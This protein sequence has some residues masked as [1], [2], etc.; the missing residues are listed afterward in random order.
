M[1][2][3]IAA[4]RAEGAAELAL[5]DVADTPAAIAEC[6]AY[7]KRQ[8]EF[9]SLYA[10]PRHSLHGELLAQAATNSTLLELVIEE[11]EDVAVSA[12]LAA[13]ASSAA[14]KL[15]VLRLNTPIL[16]AEEL[17]K[18]LERL[19]TLRELYLEYD[20]LSRTVCRHA[21]QKQIVQAAPKL[22]VLGITNFRPITRLTGLDRYVSV[23]S[24]GLEVIV[25]RPRHRE[26]MKVSQK[27]LVYSGQPHDLFVGNSL[28]VFIERGQMFVPA[29]P[30][31]WSLGSGTRPPGCFNWAELSCAQGAAALVARGS[32]EALARA[33][34]RLRYHFD[35]E[36]LTINSESPWRY[37]TTPSEL[38]LEF[39]ALSAEMPAVWT[40]LSSYLAMRCELMSAECATRPES[41]LETLVLYLA[42]A[43]RVLEL[44]AAADTTAASAVAAADT[45]S[46]LA[47]S[48]EF[49]ASVRGF[50]DAT[51][52]FTRI[53]AAAIG[54]VFEYACG[55]LAARA[56]SVDDSATRAAVLSRMEASTH[57]SLLALLA[58]TPGYS[59]VE[60]EHGSSTNA[61]TARTI[62]AFVELR[63]VD[64]P[65][66]LATATALLSPVLADALAKNPFAASASAE[67]AEPVVKIE[68]VILFSARAILAAFNPDAFVARMS[69]VE[70]LEAFAAAEFLH[71]PAECALLGK[72]VFF[73]ARGW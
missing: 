19:P 24:F 40:Q 55:L 43:S 14:S 10:H 11:S 46:T 72:I 4:A 38:V 12:V 50:G 51:N 6:T 8:Q 25:C 58:L 33:T 61:A 23:P 1:H 5:G 37:T 28:R 7:L 60:L 70:L 2:V 42:H 36:Y 65:V 31:C 56:D 47:L 53:A 26:L 15:R 17:L 21:I 22:H 44:L 41:K 64:M 30:A 68:S 39:L 73:C 35:R 66:V 9:V 63:A 57:A 13:L 71:T 3:V 48:V 34:G 20:S 69:F 32:A 52:G 16:P 45:D 62:S 29:L 54:N 27:S 49:L 18:A 67:P 59:R